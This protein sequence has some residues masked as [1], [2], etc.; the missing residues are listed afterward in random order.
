MRLVLHQ[1][2]REV[3]IISR[4]R[5]LRFPSLDSAANFLQSYAVTTQN[6]FLLRTLLSSL[7]GGLFQQADLT[8]VIVRLAEYLIRGQLKLLWD[9]DLQLPWSWPFLETPSFPVTEAAGEVE[10][11][12]LVT[13]EDESEEQEASF[14][15]SK[16]E[17][18]IPPEYPRLA[19]KEGDAVE[20]ESQRFQV[21]LDLMRYVG[22]EETEESNV[23]KAFPHIVSNQSTQ[24]QESTEGFILS[25]SALSGDGPDKTPDSQVAVAYKELRTKNERALY[26]GAEDLS[27]RLE[28]MLKGKQEPHSP[29]LPKIYKEFAER[30]QLSLQDSSQSIGKGLELLLQGDPVP[31]F[32]AQLPTEL[33]NIAGRQGD[34]LQDVSESLGEQLLKD[35]SEGAAKELPN[36]EVPES[37]KQMTRQQGE[38]L[39]TVTESISRGLTLVSKNSAEGAP[40][41]KAAEIPTLFRRTVSTQARGLGDATQRVSER[42]EALAPKVLPPKP[43]PID[44]IKIQLLG[45]DGAPQKG[46]AYHLI[47]PDGEIV[48]GVLNRR[49]EVEI[50]YL[51]EPGQ[52]KLS[53]PNLD[54]PWGFKSGASAPFQIHE[55]QQGDS[56]SKIAALYGVERWNS[57]YDHLGNESLRSLRPNP[58][59]I[60]PGDLIFIPLQEP[61]VTQIM[62][63]QEHHFRVIHPKDAPYTAQKD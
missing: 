16:P 22:Q 45:I 47:R 32:P 59:L 37:F 44:W 29:E 19:K 57:I 20:F 33:R 60:H 43:P 28:Q 18:V 62:T 40:K 39:Q 58:N 17:P 38:A 4:D 1:G 26:D 61:W 50:A 9:L 23:A 27:G 51:G 6:I 2:T 12:D 52:C 21:K 15:E 34:S 49:G 56:F 3:H 10:S 7:S 25:L 46:E 8:T 24:L 5:F 14:E 41:P 48:S 53:F 13:E 30:Q 31:L 35:L 63:G 11:R 54:L 36:S 42:M 55:V